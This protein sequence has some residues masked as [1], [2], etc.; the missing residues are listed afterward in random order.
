[1]IRV[2]SV[3]MVR[4]YKIH[5]FAVVQVFKKKSS[6][7]ILEAALE[8]ASWLKNCNRNCANAIKQC[9]IQPCPDTLQQTI[10][11]AIK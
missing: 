4:K 2:N 8:L 5:P 6:K 11:D 3:V 7:S 1:M 9:T 10:K